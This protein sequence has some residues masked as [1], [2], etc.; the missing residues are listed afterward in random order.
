MDAGRTAV[1]GALFNFSDLR[2]EPR[3][4]QKPH[5]PLWIGGHSPAALRRTA[6]LGDGWYGHVFWRNPEQLPRD[7]H[8]IKRF[9][10]QVG[11][12]PNSLTYAA[13][14]YERTFADVLRALPSYQ[15]AGLDHIVLA[16]F[17]WTEGFDEMLG[18]MERFAR[19][20]GL[21]TTS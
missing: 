2:C 8:T 1:P 3:P 9:A 14:A 12:D 7:I 4:V 13:L 20:V 17:M 11:R 16:F 15:Q 21:K 18:L 19:E 10:E 5:P 6:T